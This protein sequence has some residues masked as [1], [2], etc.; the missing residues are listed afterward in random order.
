VFVLSTFFDGA[1]AD[2]ALRWSAGG[3]AVVAIDVLPTPRAQRLSPA[4]SLAMRTLLLERAGVL[5]DLRGAGIEVITWDAGDP[6]TALRIAARTSQ[7]DRGRG[8]RG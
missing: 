4:Q 2:L 3:Q 1:A 8:V 7:R 5:D 6:M